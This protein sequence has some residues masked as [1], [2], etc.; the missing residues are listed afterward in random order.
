MKALAALPP[1]RPPPDISLRLP[2]GPRATEETAVQPRLAPA[3]PLTVDAFDD[4]ATPSW[5]Q[6]PAAAAAAAAATAATAEAT[7]VA[8]ALSVDP[9][10]SAAHTPFYEDGVGEAVAAGRSHGLLRLMELG[11]SAA[12]ADADGQPPLHVAAR[13]GRAECAKILIANTPMDTDKIKVFGSRVKVDNVS[14]VAEIELAERDFWGCLWVRTQP[15]SVPSAREADIR[16]SGACSCQQ[17][18]EESRQVLRL[19]N[20]APPLP[21][22]GLRGRVDYLNTRRSATTCKNRHTHEK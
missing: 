22:K 17:C 5:Q 4:V 18:E 21:I 8:A 10:A 20:S 1:L 2:Q 3:G 19:E 13:H 7:A 16:G 15:T 14:K 11:H 9:E 12:D 6:R